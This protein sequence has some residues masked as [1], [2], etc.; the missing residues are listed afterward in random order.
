MTLTA[1]AT[2]DVAERDALVNKIFQACLGTF[3]VAAIYLGVQ[4]GLYR[5]L[6]N[7]GSATAAELA[8]RTG[9]N[10]RY[11]R[12]W[13]EQQAVS[14]VLSVDDP[15]SDAARRRYSLPTPHAEVLLDA[16]SLA[17]MAPYP[18]QMIGTL[19]PLPALMKAFRDGG[20][21]PYEAYGA[22]CRDGI[23]AGNRV[24]FINLLGSQWFPAIPALDARLRAD[25]PA[26]VA[27]IGCGYGWSSIT[28]ARAYPKA[29]VDGFDLDPSSI[30]AARRNAREAGLADRITFELRDAATIDATHQYD[31]VTAFET[32]HDMAEPVRA[33]A[34]MRGLVAPNGTVLVIDENVASEFRTDAGDLERL[35]YG[36][37]VFHCL[38]ASM[39]QQPSAGTGTVMRSSTLRG[40]A[41]QAGFQGIEIL[42]IEHEFW[43]FYR[44]R[45]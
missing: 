14:G 23:A 35:Y 37:S 34:A 30:E 40:Y 28:I 13:L 3:D 21:V 33:L 24:S 8:K 6:A 17:F 2:T 12:E 26:R 20:G 1:D 18:G 45:A 31:L 32:I 42:P 11:I 39:V 25:P 9:T 15:R 44:L 43:R 16:D 19:R 10:E 22:D 27:D 4:L 38:P 41:E 29:R 5:S 36:F 7:D